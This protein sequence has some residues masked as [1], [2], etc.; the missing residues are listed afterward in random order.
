MKLLPCNDPDCHCTAHKRR[1]LARRLRERLTAPAVHV[2]LTL[3]H[4]HPKPPDA[5]T[6]L[7]R[8]HASHWL[9]RALRPL[10]AEWWAR[11]EAQANGWPHWHVLIDRPWSVE[12]DRDLHRLWTRGFI[13]VR[14][15]RPETI[16]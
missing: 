3:R 15:A 13:V 2:T 1:A 16:T 7:R 6:A 8:S 5:L 10:R 11:L 9:S 12:L 4:D 14:S